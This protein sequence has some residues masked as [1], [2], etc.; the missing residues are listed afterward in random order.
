MGRIEGPTG[1][2]T[3]TNRPN[4]PNLWW[5]SGLNNPTHAA[6]RHPTYPPP[7]PKTLPSCS[8]RVSMSEWEQMATISSASFS[9]VRWVGSSYVGHGSSAT[10]APPTVA[11]LARQ[12]VTSVGRLVPTGQLE[13]VRSEPACQLPPS[14]PITHRKAI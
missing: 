11:A 6:P 14:P 8:A 10:R 7:P 1:M 9:S 4:T 5:C 3:T 12:A 13:C 2:H